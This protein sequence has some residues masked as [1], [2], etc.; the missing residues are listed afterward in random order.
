MIQAEVHRNGEMIVS[1]TYAHPTLTLEAVAKL[2]ESYVVE[3]MLNVP[4][5]CTLKIRFASSAR[6]A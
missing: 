4:G 1:R 6:A 3:E 2:M 5:E